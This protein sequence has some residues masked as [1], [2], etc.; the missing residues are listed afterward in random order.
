MNTEEALRIVRATDGKYRDALSRDPLREQKNAALA[1]YERLVT[2]RY[3][4]S[5]LT[6]QQ[7][8]VEAVKLMRL[9]SDHDLLD[10]SF[11]SSGE[12]Y[13]AMQAALH[14]LDAI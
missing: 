2:P 8:L 12:S 13:R 1:E 5:L 3:V 14:K 7:E 11:R 6:A 10:D 4:E 9:D